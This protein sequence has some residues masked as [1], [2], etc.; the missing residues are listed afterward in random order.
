[1]CWLL[2]WSTSRKSLYLWSVLLAVGNVI[3]K[4]IPYFMIADVVRMLLNGKTE[5][6]AYIIKAVL[7]AIKIPDRRAETMENAIVSAL[8]QFPPQPVKAITCDR[9]A[10]FANS[11]ANSTQRGRN[12]SRVAPA[13]L[14]RNPA[15][16]N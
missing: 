2:E 11:F 3:L 10:E 6:S 7:I 5:L 14:K 1:M 15:L 9:G 13:T 4:I 12:L 16:L 8:S